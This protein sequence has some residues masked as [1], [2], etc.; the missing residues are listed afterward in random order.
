MDDIFTLSLS[1]DSEPDEPNSISLEPTSNP[2]ATRASKLRQ[3]ELQF[4]QQ[5]SSWKPVCADIQ[6]PY[7]LPLFFEPQAAVFVKK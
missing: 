5:K 4:R 6:V 1:S 3:T 2:A 7:P